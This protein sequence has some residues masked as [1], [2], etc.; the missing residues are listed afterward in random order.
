LFRVLVAPDFEI[1]AADPDFP[2]A[3]LE[4]LKTAR[5]VT[6]SNYVSFWAQMGETG[7]LSR[8][9]VSTY[10][11]AWLRKYTD[12]DYSRID[13]AITKGLSSVGA[14]IFDHNH[15]DTA[16]LAELAADAMAHGIGLYTIGIPVHVGPNINAVITFATDIDVTGDA[17]ETSATLT[18]CREQAHILALAVTER[19][20]RTEPP[21]V[22]L[23]DREIEVL[24]WGSLGK[25][26]Q[27]TADII[28]ISR[29]TVVAH[30][31]SAKSKLRVSNKAAA[32]ARALELRMFTRF[33]HKL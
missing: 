15:P 14:V 27:Q 4:T 7:L 17:D 23:T 29:W 13:P 3:L 11:A 16:E 25:T 21:K 1:T 19:F 6:G 24:Y 28:G 30:V 2:P 31:Q 20:L 5:D 9:V 12:K 22:N 8:I 10:P 18:K 26:D 32:I 33:D